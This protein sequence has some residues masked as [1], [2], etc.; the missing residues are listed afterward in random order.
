M[1]GQQE[2]DRTMYAENDHVIQDGA[3]EQ[4]AR[5]CTQLN[6]SLLTSLTCCFDDPLTSDVVLKADDTSLHAHKIV[7]AAQSTLFKAMF[8]VTPSMLLLHSV[9]YPIT[10]RR[11][12]SSS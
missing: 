6:T 5:A 2:S 7:L 12:V 9:H 10:T 1:N 8:Q 4:N 11:W 3:M